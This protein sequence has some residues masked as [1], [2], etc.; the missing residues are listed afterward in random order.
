MG[1]P[2][3][4]LRL[5]LIAGGVIIADQ[6]TKFIILGEVRM[7]AAIPVIPGFFHITHVQNPGGAFGFLAN[8]SAMV[9]GILFLAVSSLA[10]GLVLWFYHKT[11]ATHRWLAAGFALIFGGAIGNL[12]DRVRFGRVV[13]FLDFFVG[14]WHWPAFNVADSAITVGITIFIIHVIRGRIPD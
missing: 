6:V 3:K 13:D 12:I 2:A 8:Q 7:H 5:A 1:G 14:R 4:Y 9:R 11:P 10:V